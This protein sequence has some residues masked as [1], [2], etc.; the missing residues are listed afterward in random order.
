[1]LSEW[2]GGKEVYW[3]VLKTGPSNIVARLSRMRKPFVP[4]GRVI[5]RA[6]FH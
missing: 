3:L 4:S 5:L 2:R 1:M 6:A